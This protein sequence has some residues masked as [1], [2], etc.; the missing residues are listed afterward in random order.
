MLSLRWISSIWIDNS[1]SPFHTIL[2][3]F[4]LLGVMSKPVMTTLNLPNFTLGIPM[5]YLDPPAQ[6]PMPQVVLTPMQPIAVESHPPPSP[7]KPT[8]TPAPIPPHPKRAKGKNAKAT[9][10][11]QQTLPCIVCKEQGHPTQNFPKIPM[12]H[13]HLDAMDTN[14]NLPMVELPSTPTVKTSH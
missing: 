7:Q 1:S 2:F 10:E 14:E 8:T 13:A 12:I 9:T 5:W 6:P 4:P 11:P 3:L